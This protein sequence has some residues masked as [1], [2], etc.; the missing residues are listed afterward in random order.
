MLHRLQTYSMLFLASPLPDEK[1]YQFINEIKDE[2]D[3]ASSGKVT[4]ERYDNNNGVLAPSSFYAE[5]EGPETFGTL[6]RRL[7]GVAA[8][9]NDAILDVV[10]VELMS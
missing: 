3:Y 9:D 8:G 6:S 5:I 4:K 10:L 1:R 7:Q 2:L